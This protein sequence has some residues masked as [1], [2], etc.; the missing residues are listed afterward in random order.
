MEARRFAIGHVDQRLRHAVAGQIVE[1]DMLEG[2]AQLGS[3]TL[4]RPRFARQVARHIDQRNLAADHGRRH[5][6]GGYSTRL[7]LHP[8]ILCCDGARYHALS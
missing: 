3:G 4:G 8:S 6:C 2:E 7:R 5:R 1:A